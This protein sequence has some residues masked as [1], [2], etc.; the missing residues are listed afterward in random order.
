MSRDGK[1]NVEPVVTDGHE[2]LRIKHY[3]YYVASVVTLDDLEHYVPLTQL[4]E[5]AK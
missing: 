2:S 3:G 1:W 5:E 4:V